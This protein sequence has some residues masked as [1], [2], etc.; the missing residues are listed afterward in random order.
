M[1]TKRPIS[2]DFA[3]F[4]RDPN[5]PG[6][7]IS[8]TLIVETLYSS[9]QQFGEK[10]EE[11]REAENESE[12]VQWH[13]AVGEGRPHSEIIS[14]EIVGDSAPV[15]LE[16]VGGTA[17]DLT[18][19]EPIIPSGHG[20]RLL[21]ELSDPALAIA[22][23]QQQFRLPSQTGIDPSKQP[24]QRGSQGQIARSEIELYQD[25]TALDSSPFLRSANLFHRAE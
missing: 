13:A 8:S 15:S 9:T 4:D 16:I 19:V 11:S 14:K 2:W 24:T 18:V 12:I 17:L 21:L 3:R 25:L 1:A 6:A 7:M 20:A 10:L 5:R 23:A 22:I